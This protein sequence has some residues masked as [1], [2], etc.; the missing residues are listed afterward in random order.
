MA[1]DPFDKQFT[2]GACKIDRLKGSI[3]HPD[4]MRH[5]SPKAMEVL[6][7]LV[8]NAGE[9]VTR[10]DIEQQVWGTAQVS[11]EVLTRSIS[12]L[13]HAFQDHLESPE[14]IQTL[15]KR[16]Y[17][18]IAPATTP[19][20]VE[21]AGDATP[22][23]LWQEIQRRKV[24]RVA[25][26]YAGIAWLLIQFADIVFPFVA[27]SREST[28]LVVAL[29][30]LGFP[31]AVVAAWMIERTNGGLILD[32]D[33]ASGPRQRILHR[34][35]LN[36]MMIAISIIAITIAANILIRGKPAYTFEARDWVVLTHVENLTDDHLLDESLGRA[37]RISLSQSPIINLLPETLITESLLRMEYD[38]T[39]VVDRGLGAEIAIREN[40]RAVV[41]ASISSV[42]NKY[43]LVAEILNPENEAIVA[44]RSVVADSR[45]SILDALEVLVDGV[46]SDLGESLPDDTQPQHVPLQKVT[47]SN[48]DALH[49]FSIAAQRNLEGDAQAA[50]DLL[51]RAIDI[52]DEFASA[53]ALLGIILSNNGRTRAEYE[54]YWQTALS[55]GDRLP[56]REKLHIQ[57]TMSWL[58]EP[59]MME[60]AWTLVTNVFPDDA[61]AHHNLGVVY[62]QHLNQGKRA[63]DSFKRASSLPIAHRSITLI[64][65]GFAQ[66]F[67][68]HT[69]DAVTTFE[70]AYSIDKKPWNF[71]LAD[72]YIAT[73]QHKKAKSFLDDHDDLPTPMA[74]IFR[75]S[76][77]LL[78]HL[79][80]G[81]LASA[82]DALD[83]VMNNF[84][85]TDSG[86]SV[87][88][89]LLALAILEYTPNRLL[90]QDKLAQELA[91]LEDIPRQGASMSSQGHNPVVVLRVA[92][93]AARSG[94]RDM[95]QAIHDSRLI[96]E[97]ANGYPVR[98]AMHKVLGAEL[99]IARGDYETAIT[100]LDDSINQLETFEAHAALGRAHEL[101]GNYKD[102]IRHYLWIRGNR[103]R[104]FAE[105][106]EELTGRELNILDWS[107]AAYKLGRIHEKRGEPIAAARFYDQF[108]AHWEYADS[109]IPRL[110]AAKTRRSSL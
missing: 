60:R 21:K 57:A 95:A 13:R 40:A 110:V 85:T 79:D 58:D 20:T 103:G 66:L 27:I 50:I 25:V 59:K 5:V 98:V 54:P 47:T 36:I 18:L 104:A 102:A 97:E 106:H 22:T 83:Q 75:Q 2:V 51:H 61:V 99:A 94:Q 19:G 32:K 89:G 17:R 101:A 35:N 7:C 6:I 37:F 107:M 93:I 43:N 67:V 63:L 10:H 45:D 84:N 100:V 64:Y 44:S 76:R 109:D 80:R 108:I 24:V 78:Y 33:W 86:R 56:E 1:T 69:A 16:G 82:M 70:Y 30:I 11:D 9:L 88:L 72:G 65:L 34:R 46:R 74:R 96:T 53:Y 14:Y 55:L 91:F 49:A 77:Y 71:A 26:A 81:E 73:F 41:T 42:G 68:N 87:E 4:G 12:E 92:A 38:P 105:W 39:V 52:D 8:R 90:F 3:F 28:S 31:V 15:P 23:T 29:I 62:L 48:L